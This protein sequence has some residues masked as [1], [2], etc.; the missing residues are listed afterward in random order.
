M[1]LPDPDDYFGA[2][3]IFERDPLNDAEYEKTFTTY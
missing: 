1:A 2:E 3:R